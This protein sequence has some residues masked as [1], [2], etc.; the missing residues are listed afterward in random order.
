MS[1]SRPAH[2]FTIGVELTDCL[3]FYIAPYASFSLKLTLSLAK[4]MILL[5]KIEFQALFILI[6]AQLEQVVNITQPEWFLIQ[7]HQTKLTVLPQQRA[8]SFSFQLQTV[9]QFD[10]FDRVLSFGV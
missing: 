9:A 5:F 8:R 1:I 4:Q 2:H 10:R 3:R 6:A 7:I